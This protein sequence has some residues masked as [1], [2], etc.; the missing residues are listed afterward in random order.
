M[1]RGWSFRCVL[2]DG[3]H[4][5]IRL[6]WA[7]YDYW[8]PSGHISPEGIAKAVI[9]TMFEHGQALPDSFDAARVRHVVPGADDHISALTGR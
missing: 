1:A 8:C 4:A 3:S 9:L 5:T 2:V 7:D 6:N